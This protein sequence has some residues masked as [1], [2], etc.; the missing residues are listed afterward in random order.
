MTSNGAPV[1]HVAGE[2]ISTDA[3][4]APGA[5]FALHG[6]M[7]MTHNYGEAVQKETAKDILEML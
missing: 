7:T 3:E 1:V 6:V 4:I 5:Y 2:V